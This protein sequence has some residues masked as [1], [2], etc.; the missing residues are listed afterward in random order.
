MIKGLVKLF[1]KSDETMEVLID[2]YLSFPAGP[3]SPTSPA[4]TKGKSFCLSSLF[5]ALDPCS[6]KTILKRI[7]ILV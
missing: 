6:Y 3:G 2:L 7:S 5:V 1:W 4:E